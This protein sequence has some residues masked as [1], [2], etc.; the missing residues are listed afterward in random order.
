MGKMKTEANGV[1]SERLEEGSVMLA[2][3][4]D[5]SE[6]SE[7][8]KV[9]HTLTSLICLLLVKTHPQTQQEIKI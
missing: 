8:I 9:K 3:V 4:R 6:T 2:G 1:E 5:R 7:C